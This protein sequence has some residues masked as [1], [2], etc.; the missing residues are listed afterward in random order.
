[1]Y[2]CWALSQLRYVMGDSGKSMLVGFGED[3]PKRTQDRAAACPNPPE[4][5][6]VLTSLYSS[7]E[8]SH[9]LKGALVQGPGGQDDMEDVRSSD[10]ARV[11]IEMN[12]ALTGALAGIYDYPDGLWQICLQTYGVIRWNPVCGYS[13]ILG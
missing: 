9:V 12:A 1:V 3:P 2:Q 10:S 11:G 7:K 4:A 6:N 5:C 13:S 8:D